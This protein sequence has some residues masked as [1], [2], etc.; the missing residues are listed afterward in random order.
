MKNNIFLLV[1]ISIFPIYSVIPALSEN[2]M[3]FLSDLN[4]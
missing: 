4:L 1:M 2:N 3:D